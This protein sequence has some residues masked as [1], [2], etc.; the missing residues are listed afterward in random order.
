MALDLELVE[1][2]CLL[3][4]LRGR[5]EQLYHDQLALEERERAKEN[6][7]LKGAILVL[8][9]DITLLD[10]IIR[11]LWR[12]ELKKPATLVHRPPPRKEK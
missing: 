7:S 12:L 2:S 3:R 1:V 9:A 11:K 8:A 4:H 10:I 6:G 5:R